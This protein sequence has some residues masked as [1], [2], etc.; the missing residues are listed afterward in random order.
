MLTDFEERR[1]AGRWAPSPIDSLSRARLR[2]GREL[3]VIDL[4]PLGML[5]EGTT[6]LLPG[7][8]VDVHVTAA[9]GRSLVRARVVR[10]AVYNVRP[11]VVGYRGAL[12][13]CT[14]VDLTPVEQASPLEDPQPV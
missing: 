12:A 8:H 7:T 3:S 13:F 14:Q 11:D 5:V 4:S 1:R 2:A 10:C 9:R 6:R